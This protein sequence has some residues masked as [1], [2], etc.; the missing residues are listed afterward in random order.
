MHKRDLLSHYNSTL[1]VS[2]LLSVHNAHSQNKKI[3]LNILGITLKHMRTMLAGYNNTSP[4]KKVTQ[5]L[6]KKIE[7]MQRYPF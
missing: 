4:N 6:A 2:L 7:R 3:M 1:Q 5:K